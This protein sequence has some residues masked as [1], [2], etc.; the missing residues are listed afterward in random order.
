M[1]AKLKF[2]QF[3]L[4]ISNNKNPFLHEH[5]STNQQMNKN[6]ETEKE[7]NPFPIWIKKADLW[8]TVHNIHV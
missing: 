1:N 8:N 5:D 2:D 7:K 6:D 3:S 4:M